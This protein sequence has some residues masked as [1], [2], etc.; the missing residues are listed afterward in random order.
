MD[1]LGDGGAFGELLEIL[2]HLDCIRASSDMLEGQGDDGGVEGFNSLHTVFEGLAEII[3]PEGL[4]DIQDVVFQ[5]FDRLQRLIKSA[6]QIVQ[7]NSVFLAFG[8]TEFRHLTAIS[9]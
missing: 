8:T 9:P 1:V 6:P 2:E 4:L 7:R 5:P 3:V